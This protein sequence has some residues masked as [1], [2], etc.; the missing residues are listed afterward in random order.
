MLL[1]H[2]WATEASGIFGTSLLEVVVHPRHCSG[3]SANEKPRSLACDCRDAASA[4]CGMRALFSLPGI[5][6]DF[7]NVKGDLQ[8]TSVTGRAAAKSISSQCQR[9]S[10]TE[11]CLYISKVLDPQQYVGFKRGCPCLKGLL[12][13]TLPILQVYGMLEA[14]EVDVLQLIRQSR[15]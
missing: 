4:S 12:A 5:C 2:H 3:R 14:R 11:A 15:P 10:D 1:R 13:T 8:L 9:P 6:R 7:E